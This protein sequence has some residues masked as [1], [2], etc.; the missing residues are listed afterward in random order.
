MPDNNHLNKE[1]GI[2][3]VNMLESIVSSK[4][5]KM[6]ELL[7]NKDKTP[8]DEYQKA[9]KILLN[10]ILNLRKRILRELDVLIKHEEDS[11]GISGNN[12]N[13]ENS[14]EDQ[15]IK[16]I[17]SIGEKINHVYLYDLV[18]E[19]YGQVKQNLDKTFTISFTNTEESLN[20]DTPY[21][22]CKIF[23]SIVKNFGCDVQSNEF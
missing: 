2:K 22:R 14:L 10:E 5:S 8:D 12:M 18:S 15:P 7:A 21:N 16:I 9:H 17:L 3:T 20:K 1:I 13:I 11:L 6:I 19:C 23:V 4:E